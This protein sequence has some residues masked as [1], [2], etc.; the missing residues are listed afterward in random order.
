MSDKKRG[1][2]FLYLTQPSGKVPRTTLLGWRANAKERNLDQNVGS[3][4]SHQSAGEEKQTEETSHKDFGAKA[5]IVM[6]AVTK[7]TYQITCEVIALTIAPL[8]ETVQYRKGIPPIMKSVAKGKFNEG[9]QYIYIKNIALCYP[10]Y[11]VLHYCTI[12]CYALYYA[13][14]YDCAI[15]CFFTNKKQKNNLK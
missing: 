13:T 12:V 8:I 6:I 4:T 5:F 2:Y 11:Y 7:V 1:S 10:L 14:L 3:N 15:L 9:N